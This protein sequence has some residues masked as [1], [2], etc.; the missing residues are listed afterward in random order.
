MAKQAAVKDVPEF[1]IVVKRPS[2]HGPL[3]P[4]RFAISVLVTMLVTFDDLRAAALGDASGDAAL[5][6]A[7]GVAVFTWM[8]LSILNRI[9]ASSPPTGAPGPDSE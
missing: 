1:Q 3:A 8:V 5:L 4:Y 6:R 7:I 9:L 2:P